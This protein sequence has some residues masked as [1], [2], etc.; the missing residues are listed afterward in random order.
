[1]VAKWKLQIPG[2]NTV[3]ESDAIVQHGMSRRARTPLIKARHDRVRV[4]GQRA[5]VQRAVICA[6]AI[7][8]KTARIA[9]RVFGDGAV[10]QRAAIRP[11][12]PGPVVPMRQP[13]SGEAGAVRQERTS[14][15]AIPIDY[16]EL[17][18]ID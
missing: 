4:A 15:R 12:A 13:E 10:I 8:A 14:D 6:A 11:S 9:G 18:A 1:M 7:G 2:E 3:S 16:R 5:V 17:R